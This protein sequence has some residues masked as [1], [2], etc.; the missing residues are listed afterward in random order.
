M[1][2]PAMNILDAFVLSAVEG[3]SGSAELD[4]QLTGL[5]LK[6]DFAAFFPP[7]TMRRNRSSEPEA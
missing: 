4:G 7:K 1:A 6:L 5:I 3:H 2:N